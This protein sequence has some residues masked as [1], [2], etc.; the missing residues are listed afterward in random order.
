M[1]RR[2]SAKAAIINSDGKFLVLTNSFWEEYPGPAYAPDFPGGTL[3]LGETS[4]Q[5]LI[6][7]VKEEI[8]IDLTH[9]PRRPL[10]Y[11][12]LP[13]MDYAVD[14]YLVHANIRDI[15]LDEEH[16][17]FSWLTLEQM[18]ALPWWG[19]YRHLFNQLEQHLS[20][21]ETAEF[22]EYTEAIAYA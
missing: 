22:I 17:M 7:E 12:S 18:R 6:R 2:L 14:I 3:N 19:G 5:G 21:L 8:G 9:A 11:C 4:E 15:N 20:G 1:A 13:M 16:C 10:M